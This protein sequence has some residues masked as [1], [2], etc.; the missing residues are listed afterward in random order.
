LTS[1][2]AVTAFSRTL[3]Q[4]HWN[5]SYLHASAAEKQWVFAT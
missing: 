5:V 4:F 2:G 3:A 1:T